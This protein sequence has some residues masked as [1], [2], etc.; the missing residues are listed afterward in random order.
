MS[1]RFVLPLELTV[2]KAQRR[3]RDSPQ[4][5]TDYFGHEKGDGVGILIALCLGRVEQLCER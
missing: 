4:Q 2:N 5:T 3:I 1:F